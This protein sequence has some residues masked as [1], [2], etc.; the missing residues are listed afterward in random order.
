MP[1]QHHQACRSRQLFR[2]Q[3]QDRKIT[4]R[5]ELFATVFNIYRCLPTF[6]IFR[7]TCQKTTCDKLINLLFVPSQIRGV[8]SG[9]YWRMCLI[10][11]L[12]FPRSVKSA[13]LKSGITRTI[14]DMGRITCFNILRSRKFTPSWISCLLV[15]Q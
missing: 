14:L 1:L 3:H 6:S 12:A 9:V 2:S 5:M 13:L 8:G 4:S 7:A 11:V 10:V 15:Y